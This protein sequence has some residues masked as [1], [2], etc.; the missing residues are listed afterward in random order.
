MGVGYIQ[1]DQGREQSFHWRSAIKL[2]DSVLPLQVV[3]V[4]R[5]DVLARGF[6]TYQRQ[7]PS[8]RNTSSG[9][10]A[11]A[12]FYVVGHLAVRRM[13]S[14]TSQRRVV[15]L[16]AFHTQRPASDS[17]MTALQKK[18]VAGQDRTRRALTC[19]LC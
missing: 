15:V 17:I 7:D 14:L 13:R 1:F 8:M 2:F 19:F 4:V 5:D 18:G 11:N 10:S 12:F 3:Y 16:S 6:R 9:Q